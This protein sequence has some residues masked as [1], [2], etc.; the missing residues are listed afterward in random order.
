M[1]RRRSK[2]PGITARFIISFLI[3]AITPLLIATYISYTKS[4]EVLEE[5]A[6]K[7]LL[8]V[9]DYKAFR[10]EMFVSEKLKTAENLAHTSDVIMAVERLDEA[11]ESAG[12]DSELYRSI[13]KEY[14]P[15]FIYYQKSLDFEAIRL[16]NTKGKIILSTAGAPRRR[17][18]YEMVLFE[19]SEMTDAFISVKENLKTEISDF[20]Y[21]ESPGKGRLYINTPIFK[22]AQLIGV[23]SFEMGN[24]GLF[25]YAGDHRGLGKTGETIIASEKDGNIILIT[26]TRFEPEAAFSKDFEI[27]EGG[28]ESLKKA[29]KGDE[30][31]GSFTDYRGEP[32][33]SVRR[34]IPD[35]RWGIV[36]KMD[37]RE[38]YSSAANLRNTLI[39]I[40]IGLIF[41]VVIVAVAMAGSISRPIKDLTRVSSTISGGDLGARADI[42]TVDEIGDL[43]ESFNAMTAKLIE[44]KSNVETKNSE[45]E[46]QKRLLEKANKELDSFVYTA[47]HDL[48]A[49]LRGIS[50]FATFL[51]ED[52]RDKLDDEGKDFLRQIREGTRHMNDLIEDLLKLS[53]I[54]RIKNPY[55]KTDTRSLVDSVI[56]RIAYDVKEKSVDLR[57]ERGFPEIVCDKIKLGEVFLNLI[58]NAVKFSSKTDGKPVVEVGYI[59]ESDNHKFFVRDNGIGIDPKYHDQV[60][61]L[62]KRLHNE[63]EFEGTGAGLSIVKRIID[64][65]GGNIW[66]ESKA[67]EGATFYFTIPKGLSGEI[68]QG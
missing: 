55:E 12:G 68:G 50:S 30:G 15:L 44:A 24:A 20:E 32:A 35:F 66:I 17:T 5:E 63:S 46:E 21:G 6:A 45:I 2:R 10:I 58:N 64:D 60:F 48:R 37:T 27:S 4:R 47:S 23:A 41:I 14:K 36:V 62:F 19:E 49:P 61:G 26:P 28:L 16:I 33:L 43:A 3:I 1:A 39:M 7:G 11:L 52:Y 56:D 65:H 8:S 67:G 31:M 29:V 53:R 59:D 38:I 9:A 57:I 18:L 42:T 22:G 34:N 51:E 54:S 13:D 25:E 40:S